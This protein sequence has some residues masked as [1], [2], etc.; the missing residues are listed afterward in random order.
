MTLPPIRPAAHRARTGTH[1]VV[2]WDPTRLALGVE[3]RVGLRQSRI[4]EA[5]EGGAA[6]ARSEEEHARWQATRRATLDAGA[7]PTVAVE[8]VTA[9]ALAASQPVVEVD[10]ATTVTVTAEPRPAIDIERVT[11]VAVAAPAIDADVAIETVATQAGAA[12]SHDS[13]AARPSGKRFGAL[14]HAILATVP[15]DADNEAVHAAARTHGRFVGATTEEIAAAADAVRAT[16]AHP[17]LRRAAACASRDDLR[18]EA[19][20]LLRVEGGGLAEGVLDLAFR[21]RT[22]DGATWTVVDFKTDREVES[23]RARYAAQVALY[24]RAVQVATGEGA[25]GVLLVV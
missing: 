8:T 10:T 11:T 13:R 17:L 14:V 1:T 25:R 18:R 15:L 20:V 9:L 6:A 3:E 16:L 5:D 4:L 23:N 12:S 21:E 2:W 22:E 24:A 19:P 7:R